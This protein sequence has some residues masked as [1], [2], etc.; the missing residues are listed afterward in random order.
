M[1]I[2][3]CSAHAVLSANGRKAH[4]KLGGER[5]KQGGNRLAPALWVVRHPLKIFL[6][7]QAGRQRVCTYGRKPGKAFN[8]SPGRTMEWRKAEFTRQEAKAHGCCVICFAFCHRNFCH[9]GF[10]RS[11]LVFPAERHQYGTGSNA[12]IKP[13]AKPP[14]PTDFQAL[15]V[16]PECFR[17]GE[18]PEAFRLLFAVAVRRADGGNF[19]IRLLT[20]TVRIQK[21]P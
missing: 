5:T 8:Y 10:L 7:S 13:F 6:K 14:L 19:G 20:D 9:H 1:Q 21:F 18:A 15:E 11:E 3:K 12:G 2:L 17:N 16:F 4:A